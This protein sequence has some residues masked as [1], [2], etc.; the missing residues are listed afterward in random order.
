MMKTFTKLGKHSL[1]KTRM[2]QID[3]IDAAEPMGEAEQ[4]D[5]IILRYSRSEQLGD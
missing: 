1:S 2:N 3:R 4:Q 5:G